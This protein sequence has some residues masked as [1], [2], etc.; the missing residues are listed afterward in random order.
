[1][2]GLVDF[3]LAVSCVLLDRLGMVKGAWLGI[4]YVIYVHSSNGASDISIFIPFLI[5]LPVFLI[6][7]G[8]RSEKKLILQVSHVPA[9]WKDFET[10]SIH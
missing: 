4:S 10:K 5:R 2:H 9:I 8:C 7:F 3:G 6:L 1:M